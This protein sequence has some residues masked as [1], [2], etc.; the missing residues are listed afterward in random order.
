LEEKGAW[1]NS[2][3]ENARVQQGWIRAKQGKTAG[4]SRR[5]LI[6]KAIWKENEGIKKGGDDAARLIIRL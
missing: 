2:W 6:T 4:D 1:A 5:V 3:I